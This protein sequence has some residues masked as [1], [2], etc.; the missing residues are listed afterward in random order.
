ML[1]LGSLPV[2]ES[3]CSY[4]NHCGSNE[5]YECMHGGHSEDGFFA[6]CYS[7]RLEQEAEEAVDFDIEELRA[8]LERAAAEMIAEEAAEPEWARTARRNRELSE[9]L[10]IEFTI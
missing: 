8:S 3:S 10:K 1:N 7:R 5:V 2:V 4:F 6:A 9:A